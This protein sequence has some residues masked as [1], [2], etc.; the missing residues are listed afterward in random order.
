MIHCADFSIS[1][2][3]IAEQ[4]KGLSGSCLSGLFFC[5]NSY[6]SISFHDISL[7]CVVNL[8]F[9]AIKQAIC[10]YF[11]NTYLHSNYIHEIR[12]YVTFQIGYKS[13]EI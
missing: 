9:P 8:R 3:E 5:R 4:R 13:D 6:V 10:T 2:V 11:A 1:I 7:L 12:Q